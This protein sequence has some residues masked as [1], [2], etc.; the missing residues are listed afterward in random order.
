LISIYAGEER[1]GQGKVRARVSGKDRSDLR[2]GLRRR[3]LCCTPLVNSAKIVGRKTVPCLALHGRI[4]VVVWL[5]E[6]IAVKDVVD[7]GSQS[8]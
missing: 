4:G 7:L 3:P 8:P 5:R 1:E 2:H 6:R